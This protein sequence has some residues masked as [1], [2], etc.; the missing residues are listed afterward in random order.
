MPRQCNDKV[1][2]RKCWTHYSLGKSTWN[3]LMV[4]GVLCLVDS[5]GVEFVDSETMYSLLIHLHNHVSSWISGWPCKKTIMISHWTAGSVFMKEH[6]DTARVCCAMERSQENVQISVER[7]RYHDV[8]A[9]RLSHTW[10]IISSWIGFEANTIEFD[11]RSKLLTH[12]A[13]QF[14][15]Y[16]VRTEKRSFF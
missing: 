2:Q 13:W 5:N 11:F 7:L 10:L 1:F 14:E 6:Q 3:L 9:H 12:G 4:A 8:V 15:N 16:C